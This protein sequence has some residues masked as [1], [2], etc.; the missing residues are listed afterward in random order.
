MLHALT[1]LIALQLRHV[2]EMMPEGVMV[3][4]A[5]ALCPLAVSPYDFAASRQ[6][7]ERAQKRTQAWIARGGL[8]RPARAGE[9]ARHH[10]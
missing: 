8:T 9:L 7:I 6:L 5:P 4:L 3:H 2:I 1:L 10:H